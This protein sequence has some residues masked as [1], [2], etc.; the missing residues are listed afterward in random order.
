MRVHQ[1]EARMDPQPPP[2]VKAT[3]CLSSCHQCWGPGRRDTVVAA[4][5]DR[6]PPAP[7]APPALP[8]QLEEVLVV[9]GGRALEEEEEEDA[10]ERAPHH[11]N[12]AFYNTK[13]SEY[14][15]RAPSSAPALAACGSHP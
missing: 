4:P 9:V 10:A 12:F 14:P 3:A 7:Q 6:R 8:R 11:G 5:S 15:A 1:R 2:D 13:A